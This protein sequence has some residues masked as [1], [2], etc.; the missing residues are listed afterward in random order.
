MRDGRKKNIIR[1]RVQK[2]ALLVLLTAQPVLA[3]QVQTPTFSSTRLLFDSEIGTEANLGYKLPSTEYGF[4]VEQPLSKRF[5]LQS[6]L[7]YS[8]DKK[9]ITGNGNS[10][11]VSG[12]GIVWVTSRVGLSGAY[13]YS[14]LWTSQFNKNGWAP[15]AGTVIRNSLFGPGRIYV[16][17]IFP[18]GCVW[19]TPSNPCKIQSN[20]L[21]GPEFNEE[22]RVS[23]RLRVGFKLGAFHFCEQSNENDPAV[24]RQ[25]HW[26]GTE[27]A[28]VRLEFPSVRTNEP[29]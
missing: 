17:Y 12:T 2:I 28:F 22:V 21:Q 1:N 5:E 29:Y 16:S 7:S 3:W 25:C 11:L 6:S 23:S 4:S 20:R 26:G 19:A 9:I 24:P 8:P 13:D 15:S 18:T 10:F 14:W 27:L